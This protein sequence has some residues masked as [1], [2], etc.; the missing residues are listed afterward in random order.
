MG[1]ILPILGSL[2]DHESPVIKENAVSAIS[3][4]AESCGESFADYYQDTITKL[5]Q[6]F[7]MDLDKNFKQF[8]GQ[9]IEAITIISVTVGMDTFRQFSNDI[10]GKLL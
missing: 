4:V 10:I 9:L 7:D 1:E 6:F 2:L 8:K 5:L 3:S